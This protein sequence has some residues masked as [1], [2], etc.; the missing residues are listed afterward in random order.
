MIKGRKYFF[1]IVY[2]I[3]YVIYS[4]YCFNTNHVNEYHPYKISLKP[5]KR[6]VFKSRPISFFRINFYQNIV[7]LQYFVSFCC[8]AK[9]ISYLCA[10]IL[11]LLDFLPI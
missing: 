9:C 3:L 2:C 6:D 10:Y 7:A 11:F 8:T 1:F 5:V 4:E